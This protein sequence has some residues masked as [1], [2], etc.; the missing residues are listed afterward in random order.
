LLL[1]LLVILIAYLSCHMHAQKK[2]EGFPKIKETHRLMGSYIIYASAWLQAAIAKK[3]K[4]YGL[5]AAQYNVLRTLEDRDKA[6]TLIDI[7]KLMFDKSSNVSR[8]LDKLVEKGLATRTE[9]EGNRRKVDIFITEKGQSLM[10]VCVP[11]IAQIYKDTFRN[12][13]K[14][15][16]EQMNALF[17]T[18]EWDDE[19]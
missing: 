17:E 2:L 4:P 16:M 14:A 6:M 3:A 9:N 7:Q 15:Q 18:F 10:R 11:Q 8:I 19:E 1:H 5:T 13:K 12:L